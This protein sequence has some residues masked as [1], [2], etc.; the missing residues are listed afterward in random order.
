MQYNILDRPWNRK[1]GKSQEGQIKSCANNK[2]S[3]LVNVV[4]LFE[5]NPTD[6]CM[7]TLYNLYNSFVNLKCMIASK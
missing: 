1:R 7:G 5:A 6:E 4:W 3:V 2:Y